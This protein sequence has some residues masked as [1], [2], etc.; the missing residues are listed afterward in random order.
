MVRSTPGRTAIQR[1]LY[2]DGWLSLRT[3]KSY[4]L[5]QGEFS[6]LSTS[7]I[8]AKEEGRGYSYQLN[9]HWALKNRQKLSLLSNNFRLNAKF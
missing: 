3:D 1:L 9:I 4:N 8:V 5:H 6:L 7:G 2:M